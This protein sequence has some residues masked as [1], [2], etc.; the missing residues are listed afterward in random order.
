[1]HGGH[2]RGGGRGGGSVAREEEG[3]GESYGGGRPESDAWG[4]RKAGGGTDQ[5]ATTASG[6]EAQLGQATGATW[7]EQG[8]A[9][10]GRGAARQ[11][12]G[13]HVARC[14]TVLRRQGRRTWPARAAAAARVEKQRRRERGRQRGTGMQFPKNTRAQL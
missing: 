6:G 5:V 3:S 10:A 11:V 13:R 7:R 14:R 2:G 9:S 4:P 8:M 1:V 12:L